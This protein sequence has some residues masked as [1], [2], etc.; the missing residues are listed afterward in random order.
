[1]IVVFWNDLADRTIL[2]QP[3]LR[4]EALEILRSSDDQFLDLLQAAY[5][6]RRHYHGNQVKVHILLN[7]MSGLCPEDCKYCSQSKVST[8]EID[9]YRLL[10]KEEIVAA[11]KKAKAA[12]AWKFCIVTSTRGPN[13]KQLD[14]ICDAVRE[15][16][17]S[18]GIRVCTSLGILAEGQA[19]RLKSAGVDRFNHN[20]ETSRERFPDIC[21]THTYEDRVRTIE[22]VKEAGIEACSGGIVGMGESDEDLVDLA[23]SVRELEVDSI[24]VN[25][26][27]PRPGTP[28]ADLPR[29]EPRRCLRILCLFRF[30]NPS[31]DIRVAGGREVN[32]RALQPL[33]LYPCNSLFTDGY[34]TTDGNVPD[35]DLKMIEDMGF[36]VVVES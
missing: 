7:A 14:V 21:S 32:L 3:L 25:F 17:K 2:G 1:M 12:K 36:E 9:R 18:V 26:L 30:A 22:C 5:K 23:F 4:S 35:Q 15:I 33:A 20:L 19:D 10:S 31:R 27:D 24:P 16:K 28:F 8:G 11:A 34:L 6:V 13:E 29:P